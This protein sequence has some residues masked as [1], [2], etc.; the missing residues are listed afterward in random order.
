MPTNALS[1]LPE[2]T[3]WINTVLVHDLIQVKTESGASTVT[4]QNVTYNLPEI[5][6][7]NYAARMISIDD[8]N[9]ACNVTV[10]TNSANGLLDGCTFLLENT[11]FASP[12][13]ATS[14][15]PTPH[16]SA[17]WVANAASGTSNKVYRVHGSNRTVG[18]VE[19]NNSTGAGMRPVIEVPMNRMDTTIPA[20]KVTLSFDTRG[21]TPSYESRIYDQ[22]EI[23]QELPTPTKSGYTFQGWYTSTSFTEEFT[24]NTE[25]TSNIII[26][27]K[28]YLTDAVAEL[29]GEGYSS[30]SS[31][32][33]AIS[34]SNPANIKVLKNTSEIVT[35]ITSG[36]N[37]EIDLDGHVVTN[38]GDEAIFTNNGGTL[39]IKNGNLT[40]TAQGY[41]AINCRQPSNNGVTYIDNVTVNAN[42]NRSAVYVEGGTLY[43]DKG[44]VLTTSQNLRPT[45]MNTCSSCKT[46]II[47]AEIIST[48]EV[49]VSNKSGTVVIGALDSELNR[50]TPI[51]RG[52]KYGIV[53]NTNISMYDGII[54]GKTA[55]AY[56]GTLTNSGNNS[57][58]YSGS[59]NNNRI[60][61]SETGFIKTTGQETISSDTYNTLYLMAEVG[62]YQIRFDA[63]GGTVYPD[64]MLIDQG[65]SISNLPIP[66]K[67]IYHF[68][69]WYDGETQV[70]D[71]VEPDG[72]KV[73]KAK[74][75]YSSSATPVTHRTTNGVMQVYYSYISTWK[76]NEATFSD[77]MINN[78][79]DHNCSCTDN[80]CST[81]GTVYC[82][83][84][85]GFD[86]GTKEAVSVYLYDEINN[87]KGTKVNYAK[88]SNGV[89][90]NLIPGIK[91]YW[92][93]D[94]DT[95]V[96]GVVIFNSERRIIEAG[97]LRNVRDLGGLSIS[98]T[99]DNV[100]K[101]GTLKYGKLF[102]GV[103]LGTDSNNLT[104]LANLG[105]TEELELR[106]ASE[107]GTSDVRL[108]QIPGKKY[109]QQELKHYQIDRA[110]HSNYY[111]MTRGVVKKAM[112]DIV[113][114]E[115]IYFHCRIGTDRTGTL[116]Y[117][118]EGL[119]GVSDEE[120][121]QDYELS[122]FYGLVNR[123][124]YY[125]EDPNSSVSKTEK[126]VYMY[127]IIPDNNAIYEWYME[128]TDDEQADKDLINSFRTKMIDYN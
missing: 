26:Y 85:T 81:G 115:N 89:I 12:S 11:T 103:K 75:S 25:I 18:N 102:R 29:N 65:Q 31:A 90:Y 59:V 107:A 113:A 23:V 13:S 57:I 87:S 93:L 61:A 72:N 60:I 52:G 69:G 101:T 5:D 124:R 121:L 19:A 127:N 39:R 122:F 99:L 40:T 53:S 128:G 116:A 47:D 125:A 3:D 79:N 34:D 22:G 111:N 86:T 64:S 88:S 41:A 17:Y 56:N 76:N 114:G 50:N 37:V 123:T 42:G 32:I 71:G 21:G 80:T 95:N 67:G 117:I 43:L 104:E 44:S 78:F 55:P 7:S 38:N 45:V 4:S 20:N 63:D 35:P 120:K 105:V 49:P 6:Y 30:I 68:D 110:S 109:I 2:K 27:A 62:K 15:Y 112:Q 16:I 92:E 24:E 58:T 51:L 84:P 33:E 74:W 28:W 54:E 14:L 8:V 91:Y 83:K 70:F 98:Y 97:S 119:L 77:N 118:L 36:V 46:Y 100:T 9:T 108:N 106:S 94:S 66:S 126:F 96:Y 82:D 1:N 10:A 73:Y 48:S